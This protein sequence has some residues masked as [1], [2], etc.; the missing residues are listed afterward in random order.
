MLVGMLIVMLFLLTRKDNLWRFF[1]MEIAPKSK[2][3]TP[4][5]RPAVLLDCEPILDRPELAD[6]S[7]A[8][9]RVRP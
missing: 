3:A 4:L 2:R 5:G 6:H 1:Y 9:P 7:R 8:Q